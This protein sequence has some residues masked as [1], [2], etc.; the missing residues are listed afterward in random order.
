MG[1][2]ADYANGGIE[3]ET[4]GRNS[5]REQREALRRMFG[6]PGSV[7]VPDGTGTVVSEAELED[8]PEADS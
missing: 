2:M 6:D 4:T 1:D 3:V 8:Q 5:M 7:K